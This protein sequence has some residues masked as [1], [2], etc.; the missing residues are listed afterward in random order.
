MYEQVA[1][2]VLAFWIVNALEND[3]LGPGTERGATGFAT[4]FVGVAAALTGAA[5]AGT[6][7][8]G[9]VLV[10]T[11]VGRTTVGG[12]CCGVSAAVGVTPPTT[13]ATSAKAITRTVTFAKFESIFP[14]FGLLQNCY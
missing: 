7:T 9:G 12:L 4:A 14:P 13:I 6:V 5:G 3:P 11:G 1:I 8:R 2:L 10:T